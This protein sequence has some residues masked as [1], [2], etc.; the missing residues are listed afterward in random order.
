M[1]L[2]TKK[3]ESYKVSGKYFAS[4]PDI[5]GLNAL[6]I[7]ADESGAHVTF[8]KKYSKDCKWGE[9]VSFKTET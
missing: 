1:G 2:F 3:P 8:K 6:T 7:T 4:H 9:V 5:K